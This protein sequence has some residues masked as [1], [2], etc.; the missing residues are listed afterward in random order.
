MDPPPQYISSQCTSEYQMLGIKQWR[1]AAI[2]MLHLW[3]SWEHLIGFLEIGEGG[4]NG[5]L[6]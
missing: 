2:L 6:G 1:E 3:D 5:S 4:L